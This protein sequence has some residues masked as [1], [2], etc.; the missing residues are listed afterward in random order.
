[1]ILALASFVLAAEVPAPKTWADVPAYV[2]KT[3]PVGT[4]VMVKVFDK[5]GSG[6]WLTPLAQHLIGVLVKDQ[7]MRVVVGRE[8]RSDI[9]RG[10]T[11]S[12]A[13][14]DDDVLPSAGAFIGGD[15]IIALRARA[16]KQPQVE[17][18][19]RDMESNKLGL[20]T[21]A[22]PEKPVELDA[23]AIA[24]ATKSVLGGEVVHIV[25]VKPEPA[26]PGK[27]ADVFAQ[28][29]KLLATDKGV[30]VFILGRAVADG[31][32]ITVARADGVIVF[33]AQVAK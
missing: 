16:D 24:A 15:V 21:V 6:L 12:F 8:E 11:T 32:S 20:V 9:T 5:D 27:S 13:N 19:L 4:N 3:V 23:K 18:D 31:A 29:D 26:L 22:R 14:A 28:L 7:K 1:M 17:I 30:A 33:A 25:A 2:Q 10:I